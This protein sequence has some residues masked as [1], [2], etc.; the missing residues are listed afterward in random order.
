MK[1]IIRAYFVA[2]LALYLVNELV[3]GL[4]FEKGLETFLLTGVGLA[5]ILLFA[6][7]V[8]NI[9]LLP[10]NLITFGLFRW[11]SS[12]VALYLVTLIVPGFNIAKFFFKGFSSKWLDIPQF[13]LKGVIAYIAFA[14]LISL[15]TSF[16]YWV[17]K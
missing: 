14:F 13:D 2:I 15:I 16:I 1:R 17:R 11:V 3:Q 7:P 9:L 10:L 6:K 12:A 5:A 8:I 4:V